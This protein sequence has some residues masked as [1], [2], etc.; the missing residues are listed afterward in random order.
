[1]NVLKFSAIYSFFT[2][3]SRIFGF[4][5][6]ILVANFLGAGALADIFFVAFRFPNTFRRI[7]SEGALNAAFVP[8]YSKLVLG[9]EENE[10]GKFAGNIISI[11]TLSILLLVILIEIFMPFFLQLIAP[12]F[13]AEEEKFSKLVHTS[14]I[15]FPFLV[16]ISVS[17]IC[18]SILNA[19]GKFALSASLPI[20]LNIILCLSLI[21]SYYL[22]SNFLTF[23][24]W[25]VLIAGF[26]QVLLLFF[27]IKSNRIVVVFTKKI[28]HSVKSFF[29]LFIPSFFSSG[30]LQIN[31]LIG[32]IIA[33]YESGAVSYLYYADRIYQLPLALVGIAL[34]IALLPSISKKIKENSF[35]EVN[36]TI[37]KAILFSIMF[38]LPASIGLFFI[39]E[40]IVQVL[41]ER[42]EFNYIA[43]NE[44]SVALKM[45]SIGLVA[46]VLVKILTPVFFAYENA[47]LPLIVSFFN[48]IINTTLS[49]IL[50]YHIGFIGIALATSISAW[51]NVLVLYVL[52]F[53]KRYFK[54]S[55]NIFYPIFVVITASAMLGFYLYWADYYYSY[56]F[57]DLLLYK[58]SGI[59]MILISSI[60]LYFFLISFYKPFSYNEIK[61]SFLSNE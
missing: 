42:G 39:P 58:L 18:S 35:S 37:E 24:S 1:M 38:S 20:I 25:G 31:I 43:T 17:S 45:F 50:F 54:L 23:L 48:L 61:K 56:Y 44:T 59:S 40:V 27:S 7:F 52:L 9:K 6:D 13:I 19:N 12:G 26:I 2:F 16:L 55:R 30:L 49:V 32:T 29:N 47:K 8:I 5:R 21:L 36:G 46:F 14:R 4:L 41:F 3:L 34:G 22:S 51:F 28:S 53:R 10:S 57:Q 60:L 33:S 11:L 15:I